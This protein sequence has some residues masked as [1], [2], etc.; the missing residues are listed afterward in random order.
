MWFRKKKQAKANDNVLQA[1]ILKPNRSIFSYMP[2]QSTIDA[3]T[4]QAMLKDA[5][6]GSLIEQRLQKVS[7][8][9]SSIHGGTASSA[10]QAEEAVLLIERAYAHFMQAIC[11]GYAVAEVVWK[12][13]DGVWYV[14]KIVPH[15]KESVIVEDDVLYYF[16]EGIKHVAPQYK[17]IVHRHGVSPEHPAGKGILERV[18]WAWKCKQ[19]SWEYWL[20][21][22][23]RFGVPSVIALF[24]L[25]TIND[26]EA[27]KRADAIAS[28]L[29]N[30][31]SDSSVA[32]ANIKDIKTLD[33][34]G[35][36]QDFDT[37]V[38]ACNKE[39]ALAITGQSLSHLEAEHGTRAQAQVHEHTFDDIT[40]HDIQEL[41]Y[42]I[43]AT[44]MAWIHE[45]N[46][47]STKE[48]PKLVFDTKR[49]ASWEVV[50]DAIDRG[51]PVSKKA[52]YSTYG[53][54]KPRGEEDIYIAR[55]KKDAIE[56]SDSMEMEL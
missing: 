42:T 12:L 14:E 52:L 17:F 16:Q 55:A 25:D 27:Q 30:I 48:A 47:G 23:D 29:R 9:P 50:K 32:L 49:Y 3:P 7:A 44:V 51:L 8:T 10:I 40:T 35:S 2:P 21:L 18:Y 43:N 31:S 56:A 19:M 36:V 46:S 28:T 24:D 33:A 34:G 11:D 38:N 39:I 15:T 20:Q 37:L 5:V 53:L 22:A 41:E 26:D 6:V 54:P 4:K 13:E 45:L 1:Q